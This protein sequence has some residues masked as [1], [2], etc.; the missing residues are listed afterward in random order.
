MRP[1]G[2]NS[3]I[4]LHKLGPKQTILYNLGWGDTTIVSRDIKRTQRRVALL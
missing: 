1:F 4:K 2:V 3:I